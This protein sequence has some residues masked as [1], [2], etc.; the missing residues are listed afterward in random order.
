[1]RETYAHT[2]SFTQLLHKGNRYFS[3]HNIYGFYWFVQLNWS[4]IHSDNKMGNAFWVIYKLSNCDR[5]CQKNVNKAE[6]RLLN[7]L[8]SH[9]SQGKICFGLYRSVGGERWWGHSPSLSHYLSLNVLLCDS[10]C[11]GRMTVVMNQN[12]YYFKSGDT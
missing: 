6:I 3:L 10:I 8:C 2:P 4:I 11:N 12:I 5:N 1:M 9:D 7:R